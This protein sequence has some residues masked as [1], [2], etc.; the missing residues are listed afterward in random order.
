VFFTFKVFIPDLTRHYTQFPF[1]YVILWIIGT[2]VSIV[3]PLPVVY[4]LVSAGKDQVKAVTE[5]G[6]VDTVRE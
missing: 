4:F 5:T 1:S 6:A 3:T 2:V